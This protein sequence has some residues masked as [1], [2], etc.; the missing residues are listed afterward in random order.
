[1]KASQTDSPSEPAPP[2]LDADGAWQILLRAAGQSTATTGAV[3]LG[4]SPDGE[5]HELPPTHPDA[6]I[7]RTRSEWKLIDRSFDTGAP[8]RFNIGDDARELFALY[9]PMLSAPGDAPLVYAHLGQ[10]LDGFV[11]AANGA[12]HYVTGEANLVHLHRMRALAD[13]VIVG[14]QTIRADDPRLTTRRAT[15]SNPLRVVLD[16]RATLT[17]DVHVLTDDDAPTW[18]MH[19]QD[20]PPADTRTDRSHV[21]R[22]RVTCTQATRGLGLS[23]QMLDLNALLNTLH[24]RGLGR[25]FVE[26]GGRTVTAFVRAGLLDRL[27]IAVAPVF[28][29]R[30]LPGLDLA[31]VTHMDQATRPPCRH[32][33]MGDDVLFDLDLKRG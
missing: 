17:G 24:G 2:E 18:L 30:G 13:A 20:A 22:I 15:G 10:S 1:M 33:A 26:G 19:L 25:V 21:S 7:A 3:A 12:S 31:P 28:I 11:A 8:P 16:P 4:I 6:V 29:G 27:Q 5:V 9:L 23:E 32:F 14:A